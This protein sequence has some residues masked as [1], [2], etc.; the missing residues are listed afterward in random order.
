MVVVEKE[1]LFHR[2]ASCRSVS[3]RV[4][5]VLSVC[6]LA[7]ALKLPLLLPCCIHSTTVTRVTTVSTVT[8]R[9]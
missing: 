6:N 9:L 4:S 2:F 1:D 8:L 7:I 3:G 5:H